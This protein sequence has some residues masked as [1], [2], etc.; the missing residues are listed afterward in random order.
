MSLAKFDPEKEF[1]LIS[2]FDEAIDKK[3]SDMKA[4]E[5]DHDIKVLKFVEGE[6]PTIF[7]VKNILSSAQAEINEAH[8]RVE[9][10]DD[11]NLAELDVND[12]EAMKKI[13]PKVIREKQTQMMMKYFNQCCKEYQEWDEKQEKDVRY[14][15]S[16]D[17]FSLAIIQEIGTIAM[18][19][20]Q[21]GEQKRKG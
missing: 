2:V 20:A 21:L 13:K 1:E 15:C 12:E 7:I 18:V 10:P 14:P 17:T 8:I 11:L 19:R 16:A 9:L 4:Y 6:H 5:K 3:A